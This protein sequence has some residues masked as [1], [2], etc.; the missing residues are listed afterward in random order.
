MFFFAY[1]RSKLSEFYRKIVELLL[2]SMCIKVC[3]L[4]MGLSHTEVLTDPIW[5]A[6]SGVQVIPRVSLSALETFWLLVG[7]LFFTG[8]GIRQ[9][10]VRIHSPLCN[11]F[12]YQYLFI[13]YSFQLS[14]FYTVIYL[15]SSWAQGMTMVLQYLWFYHWITLTLVTT[16]LLF[17]VRLQETSLL[18]NHLIILLK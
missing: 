4:D 15:R 9:N 8:C 6:P 5:P 7:V 18:K 14:D 1:E 2:K 13:I 17:D 12:E 3:T 10:S 16:G 11:P